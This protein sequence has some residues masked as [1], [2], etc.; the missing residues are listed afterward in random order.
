M[1]EQFFQEN[2][3]RV[4]KTAVKAL[5][6][7]ILVF[8]ML[9]LMSAIGL[10]QSK[11]SDLLVLTVIG[12]IVT[13]GPSLAWKLNVPVSIMKYLSTLALG[14]L[15]ALMATNATI[16]IYMTYGLAMVFSIFYYDKKF[17][18]RVSVIS[19]L[20]LV[21]SLFFRSQNVSQI[22]FESNFV[23]FVS[24]SVGFLIEAIVMSIICTRIAAVSRNVL[25][26]LADTKQKADGM[27]KKCNEASMDLNEVVE[28]LKNTINN[29][30]STNEVIVHS[31][32]ATV[33]DFGS[34]LEFVDTVCTSMEEMNE[35]IGGI[36]ENAEQMLH[37][38]EQTSEKMED[39]IRLMEKTAGDM[40]TVEQSAHTTETSIKSLEEGVNEIAEFA[41]TIAGITSQT[42]LLALNASIEAARAGEMGRGFSVV[43][44]EVR[45][46]ADS[47]KK[48]SDSIVNIIQ[49]IYDLLNEVRT[50]NTENIEKIADGIEKIAV[51]CR[52]TGN[53]GEMQSESRDMAQNVSAASENT[54][55]YSEK[56]TQMAEK[57]RELVQNTLNQVNHIVEESESQKEVAENVESSFRHVDS[58]SQNLIQMSRG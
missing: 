15:V 34:S 7:L 45:V 4:T 39:Y 46:L 2:D 3:L 27:V 5:R 18:M 14:G 58:V 22:E 55:T 23:W 54:R 50:A 32:Q 16:G 36:T 26:N 37:I 12:A 25:V 13:L 47:S 30:G 49:K 9:I 20:L 31:A 17:T 38:S 52:E 56:V 48:A 24:R 43:A 10:F 53:L 57:M 40:R 28:N 11:I 44:E 41:S 6:W 8:P 35:T 1:T 21:A 42:N 51:V 33:Q 29:F 19:Y